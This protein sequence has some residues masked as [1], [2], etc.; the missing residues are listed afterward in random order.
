MTK[1]LL[2]KNEFTN[3]E[4]TRT[5]ASVFNQKTNKSLKF[6]YNFTSGAKFLVNNLKANKASYFL[7]LNDAIDFF[8]KY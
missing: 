8:N 2:D 6:I 7:N 5:I 4:I 3:Y 1:Y